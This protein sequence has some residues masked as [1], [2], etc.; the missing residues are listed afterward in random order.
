MT[1][2]FDLASV[3]NT[4]DEGTAAVVKRSKTEPNMV[5]DVLMDL[6][7]SVMKEQKWSHAELAHETGFTP[8]H[9]SL[10]LSGKVFGSLPAWHRILK[11]L[12]NR[13]D[14]EPNRVQ[15]AL[16]NLANRELQAQEWT[17]AE[18]ATEAKLTSAHLSDMLN[19]KVF[20]SLPAW[21]RI[22]KALIGDS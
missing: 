13:P 8:P 7:N 2:S 18:L 9:I 17:H 4:E 14:A 16:R 15:N 21:H 12:L 3:E 1:I 19:G 10:M 6:A 22:L 20:G 11:I 5:Q